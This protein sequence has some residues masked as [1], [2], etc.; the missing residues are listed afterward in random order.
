MRLIC[1]SGLS[2]AGKSVVMHALEDLGYYC[3]DNLPLGLLEALAAELGSHGAHARAAVGIDARNPGAPWQQVTAILEAIAARRVAV[4]VIFL[5][6]SD[7]VLIARFSE[8][9]RRHPLSGGATSLREAIERE[10]ELLAPLRDRADLRIDTSR[11]R[12]HDLRAMVVQRI[13]RRPAGRLSLLFESFAYRAGL[14]GDADMV[15][16]VRCLPNPYWEPALRPLSGRDPEVVRFLSRQPLVAE[17]IADLTGLLEPWIPRFEAE[18]RAYLT[19]AVGC[20]GGRHRSVYVAE[21][22]AEHF[23]EQRPEV[24]LRHREL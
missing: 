22:L 1:V 17:M 9:R 21:R 23:R 20:T 8:T 5:E 11:T 13:D 16:D 15:F 19:V 7:E 3:V 2:G 24:L 18:N 10:R 12:L 6:A 14:P 4:E